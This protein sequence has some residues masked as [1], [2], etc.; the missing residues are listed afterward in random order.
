M[1]NFPWKATKK[2]LVFLTQYENT[3]R[4]PLL[5]LLYLLQTSLCQCLQSHLRVWRFSGADTLVPAPTRSQQHPRTLQNHPSSLS[6][7]VTLW[8][9]LSTPC[10]PTQCTPCSWRPWTTHSMC[11]AVQRQR[12]RQVNNNSKRGRGGNRL[13]VLVDPKRKRLALQVK[14]KI[15][16]KI[17]KK[18]LNQL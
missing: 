17:R 1:C 8:W 7:V 5:F 6:S 18:H 2:R 12:R 3:E 15:R 10:H 9:D 13:L 16:K 14:E 11:S 4:V